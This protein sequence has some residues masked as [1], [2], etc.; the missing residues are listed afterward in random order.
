MHQHD[1]SGHQFNIWSFQTT[2]GAEE[3][4]KAPTILLDPNFIY[5]NFQL[6][7]PETPVDSGIRY[8]AARSL[9]QFAEDPELRI[10]GP[11]AREELPH[12]LNCATARNIFDN[13]QE[14]AINQ[15]DWKLYRLE[16]TADSLELYFVDMRPLRDD[17][18]GA[19]NDTIEIVQLTIHNVSIL[20]LQCHILEEALSY[21]HSEHYTCF[22]DPCAA[23]T[24]VANF[25]VEYRHSILAKSAHSIKGALQLS[26]IETTF[27]DACKYS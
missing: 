14:L 1:I 8:G 11:I 2:T 21:I 6:V 12:L 3:I 18:P 27:R 25:V 19:D 10:R 17:T 13:D 9:I 5:R 4:L 15:L 22:S 24:H 23:E 26:Q 7:A 16:L 20:Q